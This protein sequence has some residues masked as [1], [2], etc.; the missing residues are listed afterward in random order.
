MNSQEELDDALTD[1]AERAT[2][3]RGKPRGVVTPARIKRLPRDARGFPIPQAVNRDAD[4]TPHLAIIDPARAAALH[5]T[6]SCG[7]CG[8][9]LLRSEKWFV[10]A[11]VD[12]LN[13]RRGFSDPPMHEECVAFAMRV[14]L[15]LSAPVYVKKISRPDVFVALLTNSYQY[16]EKS[17]RHKD[18]IPGVYPVYYARRPWRRVTWWRAGQEITEA[19]FLSVDFQETAPR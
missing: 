15:Y 17:Y 13:S 11:P 9:K 7:I 5:E 10:G 8:E 16:R 1:A 19:E 6:H 2:M 4:G 14:C 3:T 12:V 18:R